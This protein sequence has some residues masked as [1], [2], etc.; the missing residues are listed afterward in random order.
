M[1]KYIFQNRMTDL[2]TNQ[3]IAILKHNYMGRLGY[4]AK[5]SPYIIPITYFY[6]EDANNSIIC[7]SG[8]GHKIEAMRKNNSV[9]LEV[10]EIESV[11]KWR[12]VLVHGVFEE[13]KGIDAR[14]LLHEFAEGVKNIINEKEHTLHHTISDFSSKMNQE[15]IPIVFRIKILEITGKRKEP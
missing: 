5:N 13:L 6:H 9:S 10:D 8:E 7:Y 11:N 2:K 4:I 15:K 3:C 14:H 12:S 1:I